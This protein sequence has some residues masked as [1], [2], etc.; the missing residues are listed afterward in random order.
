MTI[1]VR[2]ALALLL[3]SSTGPSPLRAHDGPPFPIVSDRV[4][5]P[6]LISVWTD[7]DTTDDGTPGGQFWVMLRR[8]DATDLPPAGTSA[9]VAIRPLDRPGGEQAATA[10]AVRGDVGNQFAA[11]VMDHEGRF[12]VRVEIGG[13][14]GAAN[15]D[16]EVTA[17]YDL[18][19]APY[20]LALYVAPFLL[21]GLLWGRVLV[22][23]RA[24]QRERDAPR[25]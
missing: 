12:H 7:P 22:H 20:L 16:A 11:V 15:V 14:L 3:A 13:P 1:R 4:A 17:T 6:Y 9:V 18:R 25:R 19:P 2:I 5:G 23:R 10:L 8:A 21:V 24:M